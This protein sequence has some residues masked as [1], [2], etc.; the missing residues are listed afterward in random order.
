MKQATAWLFVGS[1]ALA[2]AACDNAGTTGND[3]GTNPLLEP[4]VEV[5]KADTQYYNPD[6]IEVEV[7]I[8]ADLEASSY[9]KATGPAI[10]GQF[11]MTYLRNKGSIY[12]E[13]LAEQASSKD[14]VEWLIDGNWVTAGAASAVSADK[15]TH[16]RIRGVNAVL[17]Q[18]YVNGVDI[19]SE[20]KAPVPVA[21]FSIYSDA[22]ASCGE[23][24]GHIGLSQSTYWYAWDPDKAGCTARLQQLKVTVTKLLPSTVTYPEYDQ[25]VAD[26]KVTMVILFGQIGDGPIDDSET[27]VR[28]MKL[29][30]T[31]LKQAKFT[32]VTKPPVGRRFRKTVGPAV[33]EVDL[34]GPSDFAGL[35]DYSHFDNFQRA[36]S[37]HEIV[38]YDGH[39]MLGASD[40]WSR[41]TYPKTYQIFLYGGCLGYEYYI[42]PILAG[43][44][45]TWANL[46]MLSAVVEV[47]APANDFAGPFLAKL[48]IA[49][50]KGFKVSWK[51]ILGAIRT[52]V[53][54][55]TFGMSGVRENCF[56][57]GGSRCTTP[58]PATGTHVYEAH[59]GTAIPDNKATGISSQITVPDTFTVATL[60]VHVTIHHTYVGDLSVVLEKDGVKATLWDGAGAGGVEIDQSFDV[61]NFAGVS[62][63]GNW[64]LRVVDQAAQDV[65]TLDAWSLTATER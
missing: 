41:P 17:L 27:G 22:G 8:E 25:L 44:G 56:T 37:D 3:G 40:Y 46:D 39:S 43:K 14:R 35:S 36:I 15:K 34:Y 59:P 5:G 49:L 51:D 16:F 19:G 30:A 18:R 52:R 31:W 28:N 12:L 26:G 63:K 55:S 60:S 9:Q 10:L 33:V 64:T 58:T 23:D 29:F 45:G 38:V 61:S 13:S 42:V 2:L 50:G 1:I 6:G 47:S 21:P 11:A 65:G 20:F 4:E 53:G 24:D 7:D 48:L 57:P 32:E 62:A 54:D